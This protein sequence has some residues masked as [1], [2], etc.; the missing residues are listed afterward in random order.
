MLYRLEVENFGSIKSQQILDLRIGKGVPDDGERFVPIYPGSKDRVPKVIGIFGANAS[1][2]STLL[3]ALTFIPWFIQH[4]YPPQFV[5]L[6]IS[7]FNSDLDISRPIKLAIEFCG[8]IE[9]PSTSQKEFNFFRFEIY[10]KFIGG[11]WTVREEI[12][13]YKSIGRSSWMRLAHRNESG[14]ITDS[15][16]FQ[17]SKDYPRKI[18]SHSSLIPYF[19]HHGHPFALSLWTLSRMISS[20]LIYAGPGLPLLTRDSFIGQAQVDQW[21]TNYFSANNSM[22]NN[23][24]NELNKIDVGITDISFMEFNGGNRLQFSHSGIDSPLPWL[25]ES[26]GTRTY[27]EVLPLILERLNAHGVTIIDEIDAAIHPSL[28]KEIV[29]RYYKQD[30]GKEAQLWVAGHSVS[31]LQDFSKEEIV[32]C[33]K[34]ED[35]ETEFYRLADVNGVKRTENFFRQYLDGAYGAIP[36]LG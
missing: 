30:A 35:G 12:L 15:K 31:L 6:P 18:P 7:S 13:K 17:I 19:A 9:S 2:K 23:V 3:R 10:F 5:P 32:F 36:N 21:L 22:F 14:L 29:G 8:E 25:Y 1:G 4:S 33:E 27:I 26:N 24:K 20:N 16:F 11:S 34:S 28:N